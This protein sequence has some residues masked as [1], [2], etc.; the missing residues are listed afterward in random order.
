MEEKHTCLFNKNEWIFS[1]FSRQVS[2]KTWGVT[3]DLLL[4]G[5]ATWFSQPV[6]PGNFLNFILAS[7]I[8]VSLSGILPF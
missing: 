3:G 8:I 1:I 5:Q 4:L 7:D 2:S 6:Q